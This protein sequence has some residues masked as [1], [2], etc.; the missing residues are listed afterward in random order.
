MSWGW[1]AHHIHLENH[2]NCFPIPSYDLPI[3]DFNSLLLGLK[4]NWKAAVHIPR[5]ANQEACPAWLVRVVALRVHSQA[6]MLATLHRQ[7]PAWTPL[8]TQGQPEGWKS[9]FTPSLTSPHPTVKACTGDVFSNRILP[10]GSS[11]Q[12]T[13][14]VT[15]FYYLWGFRGFSDQ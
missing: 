12:S 8:S 6:G 15:A 7:K 14:V 3:P 11:I 10:S 1:W 13:I 4:S 9:Q 2:R 5:I